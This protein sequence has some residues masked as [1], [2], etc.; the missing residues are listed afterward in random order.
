MAVELE[1][2]SRGGLTSDG[3]RGVIETRACRFT[4]TTAVLS[5]LVFSPALTA[6]FSLLSVPKVEHHLLYCSSKID[7]KSS[8]VKAL[9]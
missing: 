4:S 1:D 2:V 9:A 8:P 7:I 6:S 3:I 5:V